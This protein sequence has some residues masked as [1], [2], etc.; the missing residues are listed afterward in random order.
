MNNILKVFFTKC[1][2]Q[3]K[4]ILTSM[5][6]LCA[7]CVWHAIIPVIMV[8]GPSGSSNMSLM[9]SW[10][11]GNSIKQIHEDD[12]KLAIQYD[13]Y[14]LMVIGLFY[15][16]F[17]I[18]FFSVIFVQVS[19]ISIVHYFLLWPLYLEKSASQKYMCDI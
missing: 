8:S 12:L 15:L 18:V 17:H 7:I 10:V 4:Y 2:F 16:I 5:C 3:D 11:I 19:I 9:A 1:Y 6:T 13:G 14:A